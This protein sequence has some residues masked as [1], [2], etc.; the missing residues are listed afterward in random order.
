VPAIAGRIGRIG[1][2]RDDALD[3]HRA[4]LVVKSRTLPD[5]MVAVVGAWRSIREQGPETLLPLDQGALAQILAVEMEKVE[6][7]EDQRRRVAAV[8]CQLDDIEHSDAVGTDAAQFAVE[9]SLASSE[10]RH[11]FGDRRIFVGPVEPGAGQQFDAAAVEARMYPVA[12]IFDFVEPLVAVRRRLDQLRQLRRD[13][14]R[15]TGRAGAREERYGTR[16]V[17]IGLLHR[18]MRR[19]ENDRSQTFLGGMGKLEAPAFAIPIAPRAPHN[20]M[21]CGYSSLSA[22][23]RICEHGSAIGG[24]SWSGKEAGGSLL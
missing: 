7:K 6:Q 24:T 3:L 2:F 1:A 16:H 9:V 11:S 15:Q 8:R 22:G 23:D 20:L 5:D 10:L 12:I 17:G 18:G 21:I 19:F 14:F 4:G 13:E